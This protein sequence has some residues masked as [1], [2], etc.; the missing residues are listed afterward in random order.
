[1][2]PPNDPRP[3]PAENGDY[4]TGSVTFERR[5]REWIFHHRGI[6]LVV[7]LKEEMIWSLEC[8]WHWE[9]PGQSR[10]KTDEGE[11]TG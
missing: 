1:M 11:G 7:Y 4:T 2:V 6:L 9:L 8:V 5:A 3:G 10:A